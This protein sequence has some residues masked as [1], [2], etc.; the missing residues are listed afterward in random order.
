[1]LWVLGACL[2]R[3]IRI[4]P[5]RYPWPDHSTG[6]PR[7]LFHTMGLA[8]EHISRRTAA[9]PRLP[10]GPGSGMLE[11]TARWPD[12]G[13]RCPKCACYT[14]GPCG[15]RIR[16][17]SRCARTCYSTSAVESGCSS[18]ALSVPWWEHTQGPPLRYT[19]TAPGI[20]IFYPTRWW[21]TTCRHVPRTRRHTA[22]RRL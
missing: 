16:P 3:Q 10:A 2:A 6:R 13:M 17:H 5:C 11:S 4:G 21:R 15:A 18:A 12:R 20:C 1:M 8:Y 14:I 9:E 7:G 22:G 19:L